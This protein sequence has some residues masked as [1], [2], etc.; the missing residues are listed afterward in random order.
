MPE[1]DRDAPEAVGEQPAQREVPPAQVGGVGSDALL[2]VDDAGHGDAGRE[3][4]GAEVLD[5]VRAQLGG[6][7]E[8]AV[9]DRVGAAVAAGRPAGLVQE[10]AARADQGGLHPGAAHVEGDDMSHGR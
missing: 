4:G 7:V 3:R 6:E 8:D 1:G 5:A 2:L 10:L 9:D